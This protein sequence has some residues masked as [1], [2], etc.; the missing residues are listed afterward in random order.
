MRFGHKAVPMALAAVLI[1]TIGFGI[2][3]PVFPALLT[4]LGHAD[5]EHAKIGRASCRERV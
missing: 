4:S 1:D 5:I 2:V 3:A